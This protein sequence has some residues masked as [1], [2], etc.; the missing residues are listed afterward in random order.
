[1]ALAAFCFLLLPHDT[2]GKPMSANLEE[3][4]S[5]LRHDWHAAAAGGAYEAYFPSSPREVQ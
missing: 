2:A 3:W 4:G 5:D 1:M